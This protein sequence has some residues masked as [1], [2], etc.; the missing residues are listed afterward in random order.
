MSRESPIQDITR[1]CHHWPGTHPTPRTN[2]A[3]ECKARSNWQSYPQRFHLKQNIATSKAE[4]SNTQQGLPD[5][6]YT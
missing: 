1:S 5:W 3:E 6:G 4:Y 2:Q